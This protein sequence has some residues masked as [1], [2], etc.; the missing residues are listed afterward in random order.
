MGHAV[1][2][3]NLSPIGIELYVNDEAYLNDDN[4]LF[5]N[6]EEGGWPFA[7]RTIKIFG[8]WQKM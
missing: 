2:L 1:A 5:S 4:N 8:W 6:S 3:S 7:G